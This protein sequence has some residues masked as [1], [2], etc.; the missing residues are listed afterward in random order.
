MDNYWLCPL[1]SFTCHPDEVSFSPPESIDI[2]ENIQIQ[3]L[4]PE[5]RNY[6]AEFYPNLVEAGTAEYMVVMPYMRTIS[7]GKDNLFT[8]IDEK[9]RLLVDLITALRLCH[10]GSVIPGPLVSAWPSILC[11]N[12]P[13]ISKTEVDLNLFEPLEYEFYPSDAPTVSKLIREI[14]NRSK[15]R[16][17]STFDEALRRFNSA[18]NGELED[19]LIDQM[20]SFESLYIGDDKELG[21]KL[22]LRTA[23]LLGQKRKRIFNDMKKAYTL[24]GQIVHG[25][26]EVESSTIEEILP[27]TEEY[28]R[29]SIRKFLYFLSQGKSLEQIRG[30][31]D[32]NILYNGKILALRE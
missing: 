30:L 28:L 22:A 7:H 8:E 23:F 19:R 13:Y 11:V 20:I 26:K 9:T 4:T 5:I 27:K 25:N 18:Y 15:Y 2:F 6:F 1:F 29:Q 14:R 24:R 12:Y 17:Y 3:L 32:E 31:L 21:Y 10:A 16:K